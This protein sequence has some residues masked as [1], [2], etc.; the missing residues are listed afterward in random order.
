MT[1]FEHHDCDECQLTVSKHTPDHRGHVVIIE[2]SSPVGLT[3]GEVDQLVRFLRPDG[4]SDLWFYV[5]VELSNT[6]FMF[7]IGIMSLVS[8]SP[9]LGRRRISMCSPSR[10]PRLTD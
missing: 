2:T 4:V 5:S 10:R 9:P 1:I 6:L 7:V 3:E 8:L